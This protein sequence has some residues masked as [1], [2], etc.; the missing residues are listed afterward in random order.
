MK[1]KDND[2]TG[3]GYCLYCRKKLTMNERVLAPIR[4]ITSDKQG[5]DRDKGIICKECRDNEIKQRT[6]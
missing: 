5:Y 1:S 6:K 3:S 4:Y 2:V